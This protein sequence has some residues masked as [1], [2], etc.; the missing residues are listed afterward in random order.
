MA[1]ILFRKTL[2]F[3]IIILFIGL[4]INSSIGSITTK[5]VAKDNSSSQTYFGD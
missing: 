2:A 4:S 5:N 3:T 1:N